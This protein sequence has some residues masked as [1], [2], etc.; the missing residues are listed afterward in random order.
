[1][2][3][4]DK[5]LLQANSY[6]TLPRQIKD[7]LPDWCTD[8][9]TFQQYKQLIQVS[10]DLKRDQ[11]ILDTKIK[12]KLDHVFHEKN[13]SN[14]FLLNVLAVGESTNSNQKTVWISIAAVLI[15]ALVS[16]VFLL[17]NTPNEVIKNRQLKAKIEKVESK[18]ELK[19]QDVKSTKP[20]IQIQAVQVPV[21]LAVA[22]E[23]DSAL[24][25]YE[26]EPSLMS[27]DAEVTF[28]TSRGEALSIQ[29]YSVP[30]VNMSYSLA[31]PLF[32]D[33]FDLIE[34]TF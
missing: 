17:Q 34:P 33:V 14:W 15:V 10:H 30:A 12:Q 6:S 16:A 22:D 21:Q 28:E 7:E 13:K 25:Q 27:A 18:H 1:M 19:E 32:N 8:E 31:D 4:Q 24:P 2:E 20:A 3:N 9:S 11:F 5:Q 26:R 29:G 23:I